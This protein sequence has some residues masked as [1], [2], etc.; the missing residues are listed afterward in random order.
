[1]WSGNLHSKQIEL[2][3]F[4]M[5]QAFPT[6]D[7]YGNSADMMDIRVNS[8]VTQSIIGIPSSLPSFICWT[9]SYW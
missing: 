6:A 8:L 5:W 7:Y 1:M 3:P 9:S 2:F 4:A